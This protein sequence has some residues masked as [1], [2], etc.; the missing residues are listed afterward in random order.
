MYT[1]RGVALAINGTLLSS[2]MIAF[3]AFPAFPASAAP[4]GPCGSTIH[5][6]DGTAWQC[7]FSDEFTGA[8]VDTTRWLAQTNMAAGDPSAYA[9]YVDSPSNISESSGALHLTVRRVA[10]PIACAGQSNPTNYTAGM[11]STYHLFSQ[12]YGRFEARMRATATTEP[13]LHEAFWLWP[14]NRYTAINWPTTGEIDVAETYS[15]Y[16]N[17]AVPYLHYTSDDNG[18]PIVGTNTAYCGAQRG[19]WN[20]YTLEWTPTSITISVNGQ[21]CL[22]NTSGDPAFNERYIVALSA[23]LG[24]GADALTASTPI[25]ATTDV[26]YVRVWS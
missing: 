26:D 7:T 19:V 2:V 5:K 14:D 16:S 13:G 1:K 10:K 11:L 22:M 24:L 18:G 3:P 25:P 17:L 21:T 8:R 9:C 6:A 20:T 23:T 15:N 4:A 12:Q